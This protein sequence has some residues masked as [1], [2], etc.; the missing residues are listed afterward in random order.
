LRLCLLGRTRLDGAGD[1]LGGDWVAHRPGQVLKY[2]ALARGRAVTVDELLDAV[3]PGAGRSGATNV[4]QAIHTL[5]DRLEPGRER[6]VRSAIVRSVRGGYALAGD[7]VLDLDRFE[8]HAR[9]GLAALRAGDDAGARRELAAAAA[10]Y[11]GD[12]LADEPYADWALAE[13]ER[14]RDLAGQVLAALAGLEEGVGELDAAADH[15]QRLSALDPLDLESQR[16][17]IGLLLR[18]GR[19]SEALR[20]WELVRRRYRRAFG[21]DPVLDVGITVTAA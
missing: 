8:D 11:E 12:L 4:R 7:I 18:R 16:R 15:L 17:V 21:E 14:V 1:A 20:R 5:R 6:G 9:A 2:L 3:W 13:R 19:R 10:L